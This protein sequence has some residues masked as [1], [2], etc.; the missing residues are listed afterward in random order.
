[1]VDGGSRDES[2]EITEGG[3]DWGNDCTQ[4]SLPGNFLEDTISDPPQKKRR[5]DSNGEENGV[6]SRGYH[7]G[8]KLMHVKR[9]EDMVYHPKLIGLDDLCLRIVN[10]RQVRLSAL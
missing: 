5:T 3:D 4:T 6:D 1:V 10:T 2:H 8:K 7:K 9:M